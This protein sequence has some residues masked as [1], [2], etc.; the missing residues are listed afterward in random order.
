MFSGHHFPFRYHMECLNPPVEFVPMDEWYCPACASSVDPEEDGHERRAFI[1][2]EPHSRT[3]ASH[4]R[5]GHVREEE[6]EEKLTP[7]LSRVAQRRPQR[8]PCGGTAR[9][10]TSSGR[11]GISLQKALVVLACFFLCFITCLETLR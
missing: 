8:R 3:R 2:S 6:E 4:S 5:S 7:H 1:D 10:V 11:T 9:G